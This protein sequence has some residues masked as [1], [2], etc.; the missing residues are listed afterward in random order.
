MGFSFVQPGQT[1]GRARL[2]SQAGQG[3][4][5]RGGPPG[6]LPA[7]PAAPLWAINSPEPLQ[8]QVVFYEPAPGQ[9][10]KLDKTCFG[11]C[12]FTGAAGQCGNE[13]GQP[14]EGYGFSVQMVF[15]A[16][17][18]QDWV[19]VIQQS[20][21]GSGAQGDVYLANSGCVAVGTVDA[22]DSREIKFALELR[23]T[24]TP[25]ERLQQLAKGNADHLARLTAQ[26]NDRAGR[27][28]CRIQITGKRTG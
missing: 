1:G 20:S 21:A 13:R 17:H 10:A 24:V 25:Q 3:G 27:Y 16:A 8:M 28:M 12:S 14:Q 11:Y 6:P 23:Y 22:S 26:S 7:G 15:S 18:K 2:T 5:A 19:G 9:E 4:N